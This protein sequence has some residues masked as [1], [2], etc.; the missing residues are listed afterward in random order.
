MLKRM[1]DE[2]YLLE[3]E[4]RQGRGRGRGPNDMSV[5]SDEDD[6]DIGAPSYPVHNLSKDEEDKEVHSTEEVAVKD[7]AGPQLSMEVV[8]T[9]MKGTKRH[10]KIAPNMIINQAILDHYRTVSQARARG[11]YGSFFPRSC[12]EVA[13]GYLRPRRR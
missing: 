2:E 11:T 9:A 1:S 3:E 5:S 10:N 13:P 6:D 7:V 4:R 12:S 8:K